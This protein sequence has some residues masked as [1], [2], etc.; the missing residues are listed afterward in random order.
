MGVKACDRT[1]C[2]NI[3]CDRLILNGDAYVCDECWRELLQYADTWPE[4]ISVSEVRKLVEEFMSTRPGSMLKREV[5][6]ADAFEE[7]T[8]YKL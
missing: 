5:S 3:M 1:A 2:E 7:V 8:G 6:R 4:R